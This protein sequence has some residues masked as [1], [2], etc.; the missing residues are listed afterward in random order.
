[1]SSI[2]QTPEEHEARLTTIRRQLIELQPVRQELLHQLRV[3]EL[4]IE[5]LCKEKDILERSKIKIKI[6]RAGESGL[7]NNIAHAK[8]VDT[9][10]AIKGLDKSQTADLLEQLLRMQ[11]EMEHDDSEEHAI[12]TAL[13]LAEDE[14]PEMEPYC[15]DDEEYDEI[16]LTDPEDVEHNPATEGSDYV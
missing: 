11:R 2:P 3:C 6:C 15:E 12:T 4:K 9:V 5:G 14:H 10:K 7:K 16:D 13:E 1:M 8:P